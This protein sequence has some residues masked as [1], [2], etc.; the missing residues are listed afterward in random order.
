MEAA[1]LVRAGA[2][3]PF[4]LIG[5]APAADITGADEPGKNEP[6]KTEIDP[7]HSCVVAVDN[8]LWVEARRREGWNPEQ[9]Q[10]GCELEVMADLFDRL[11]A[12]RPSV[13]VLA[14]GGDA[15][16]REVRMHLDAGRR[17]ILIEGSGRAADA[18]VSLLRGTGVAGDEMNA[19]RRT[20]ESLGLL[21]RPTLY[22][23]VTLS[24]GAPALADALCRYLTRV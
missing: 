7:N 9:G 17:V 5:V 14:N 4:P 8:P 22:T 2:R 6:G 19:L 10:W 24:D 23:V 18:I 21:S 11:S 12:G 16:L 1:G 3:E 13:A 20:A 15:A